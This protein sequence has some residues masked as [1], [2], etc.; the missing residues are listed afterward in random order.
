MPDTPRDLTITASSPTTFT[1]VVGEPIEHAC[2]VMVLDARTLRPVR[3]QG[4]RF[5]V[6]EGPV[7]LAGRRRRGTV[8]TTD[9]SGTA[10]V[11]AVF[12]ERGAA[13]VSAR[14]VGTRVLPVF[15]GGRSDGVTDQIFLY[16]DPTF[17]AEGGAVTARI[18]A[19][20]HRGDPVEGAVLHFEGGLP[21][22]DVVVGTVSEGGNGLYHGRFET[23]RAGQ[24]TLTC[25]DLDSRAIARRC[26]H[27]LPGPPTDFAVDDLDP[28]AAEPYGE[29][30]V[31]ARLVDR[32][33]NSLDP[34]G[35]TAS[36]DGV[37]LSRRALYGDEARFDIRF[38]G[39]GTVGLTLTDEES[40]VAFEAPVEFAAVWLRD[41][42]VVF[43]EEVFS[44]QVFALPPPD[45]PADHATLEITF[46]PAFVAFE[47]VAGVAPGLAVEA[48]IEREHT[49][50][51]E[52]SSEQPIT[53][54]EYPDGFPVC[55]VTWVC[56]GEGDTCF[57]CIGRMSP[58]T[59]PWELC[60]IQKANRR[61]SVCVNVIYKSGDATARANGVTAA[62]QI[63]TVISS[64][65]NVARCCP[66]LTVNVSTRAMNAAAWTRVNAAIGNDGKVSSKAD[67]D[68]LF[69][70]AVGMRDDCINFM[71]ID[72]DWD[73]FD[74]WTYFKKPFNS[75][76][77]FG[78]MKPDKAA[79]VANIGAHEAGHA[80]DLRHEGASG[81]NLMSQSQ[82][83]G[84]KLTREQCRK[85]F[86]NL[87]LFG[88]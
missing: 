54:P 23:N 84:T 73:G 76:R 44:T 21:A 25:Q 65:D 60:P 85:I 71:M 80:F 70:T 62:R 22:D 19:V 56:L 69:S 64:T 87:G 83:H 47:A 8:V 10:A 12:V 61:D 78:V 9:R 6:V 26:V 14:L 67:M 74:G 51:L 55:E 24:W 1:G 48:R 16:G 43:A 2:R 33:G 59:S 40:G 72:M 41:P 20:D 4:V 7:R 13:L 45:R 29:V 82:P 32:F 81:D 53:A 68:A 31:R 77:G 66:V 57:S 88:G 18:V 58:S 3:G 38:A 46:D 50:V 39:Y 5:S 36:A 49:L 52:V 63:G 35:I 17:P 75:D 11:S 42:G 79:S 30:T 15:F 27:V 37:E 34:H 86:E 28:R